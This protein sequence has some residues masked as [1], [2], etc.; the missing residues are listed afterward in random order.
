M[1][2]ASDSTPEGLELN[3]SPDV[4]GVRMHNFLLSKKPAV[5][6]TSTKDRIGE[7]FSQA[8]AR[9]SMIEFRAFV[10]KH[11][12]KLITPENFDSEIALE[13]PGVAYDH[14]MAHLE[15]TVVAVL[16][17]DAVKIELSEEH[18]GGFNKAEVAKVALSSLPTVI[19][20]LRQMPTK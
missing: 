12:R 5:I 10:K 18:L 17:R 1:S 7:T 2:I 11:I 19:R 9:E 4:E 3:I 20:N 13:I 6:A 16:G 15:D 8:E 14:F